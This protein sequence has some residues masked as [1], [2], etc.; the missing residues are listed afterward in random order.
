VASN[1]CFDELRRRKRRP[2]PTEDL[3]PDAGP[4]P[5][6]FETTV[7]DRDAIDA[8]L[9]RLPVEFRT[10]VVLRDVLGLDY[11]EIGKVLEVPPGTVRSRIARGRAALAEHLGN[12]AGAENVPR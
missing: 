9:A 2:F 10:A 1:A 12:P 3:P 5:I 4:R 6:A 7:A 8:A 11:A